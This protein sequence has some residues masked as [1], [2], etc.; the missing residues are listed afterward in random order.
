MPLDPRAGIPQNAQPMQGGQGLMD[1]PPEVLR[2]LLAKIQ[3]AGGAG[4][5]QPY[6]SPEQM[7][8]QGQGD[9]EALLRQIMQSGR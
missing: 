3:G 2:M 9:P 6:Q 4:A 5:P 8:G 1:L 7:A